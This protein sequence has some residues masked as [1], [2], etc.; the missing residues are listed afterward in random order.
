MKILAIDSGYD[1]CGY[2]VF[3]N[4]SL[5]EYGCFL[6]NK[7]DPISQR[8]NT[9]INKIDILF[10]KI[11]FEKIILEEIFFAKNQKTAIG[12]AQSQGAILSFAGEKKIPCEMINPLKVKQCITGYGTSDKKQVQK[13]VNL[14][15]KI[16]TK[17]ELDD[18]C[19]AIAIGYSYNAI[20]KF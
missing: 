19:D 6:S 16:D 9:L 4:D 1:R 5:L 17:K 10:K 2:A 8:L 11:S 12:V 7:K 20:C 13:M 3:D 15:F 14:I 18:T